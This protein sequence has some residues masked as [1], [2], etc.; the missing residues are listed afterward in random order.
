LSRIASLVR[1]LEDVP[2]SS[3]V[4][5][6]LDHVQEWFSLEVIAG[7]PAAE[8][9]HLSSAEADS[10]RRL[11]GFVMEAGFFGAPRPLL[12]SVREATR[13]WRPMGPGEWWFR[14]LCVLFRKKYKP[15]RPDAEHD[16]D[17]VDEPRHGFPG[18]TDREQ[19]TFAL[20]NL[21]RNSALHGTPLPQALRAPSPDQLER[22]EASLR[23]MRDAERK[24]GRPASA[25]KQ[26]RLF[27]EAFGLR[28]QRLVDLQR[29][30]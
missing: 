26:A 27:V 16:E 10:A 15:L 12:D 28:P 2:A 24:P 19:V 14:S 5:A 9:E 13:A 20:V 17:E 23:L 6:V 11:M 22:A 1:W 4:W 7:A 21:A 25:E 29:I 3:P 30:R 18:K 8:R